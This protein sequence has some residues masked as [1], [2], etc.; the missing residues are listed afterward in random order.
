MKEIKFRGIAKC[1]GSWIYGDLIHNGF[2]GISRIITI[3]IASAGCYPVEVIPETVGQFTG[4]HDKNGKE[5]YE[6]DILCFTGLS[7]QHQEPF[8]IEWRENDAR[9]TDYSP[10]DKAEIIGNIWENPDS[11]KE[12]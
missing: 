6:G 7:K 5:I 10:K 12:G 3:G 4:L 11:I 2:D 9:Y 1:T 8:V